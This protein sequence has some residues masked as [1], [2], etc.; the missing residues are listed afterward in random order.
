MT[1]TPLMVRFNVLKEDMLLIQRFSWDQTFSQWDR[2]L[3]W[4]PAV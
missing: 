1:I 3:G 4:A 2:T